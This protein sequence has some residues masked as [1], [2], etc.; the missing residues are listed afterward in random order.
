M[1]ERITRILTLTS[2]SFCTL[3]LVGIMLVGKA[4][5]DGFAI[6]VNKSN[7]TDNVSFQ[8]LVRY[9]KAEKQFWPNRKKVVVILREAG[10]EE[11]EVLLEKIY[12]ATEWELRRMWVRKIYKGDI[13]SPPMPAFSP[14]AMIK[15]IMKK[16]GGIGIV[17]IED[18]TED[19]KVLKIDGNLPLD[20]EYPLDK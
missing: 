3:A 13:T 7:N 2:W 19:V 11:Q 14:S 15:T 1:K 18:V 4:S 10:S 9:F 8:D 16:K 12:R 6:V 5:A 17:K 20:E